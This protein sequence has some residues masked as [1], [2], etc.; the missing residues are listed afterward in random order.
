MKSRC[1]TAG[2]GYLKHSTAGTAYALDR[3]SDWLRADVAIPAGR[4]LGVVRETTRLLAVGQLRVSDEAGA[5]E[6][7]VYQFWS[8]RCL[9]SAWIEAKFHDGFS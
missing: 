5:A 4:A 8:A 6:F 7:P 9:G 3:I 1:D 2:I